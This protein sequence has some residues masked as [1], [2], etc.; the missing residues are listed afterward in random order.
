MT[1]SLKSHDELHTTNRPVNDPVQPVPLPAAISNGNPPGRRHLIHGRFS[2][3]LAYSGT[4]LVLMGGIGIGHGG[5][6]L[7]LIGALIALPFLAET[8]ER[9][10]SHQQDLTDA[11]TLRAEARSGRAIE[12]IEPVALRAEGLELRADEACLIDGCPVEVLS[13]Y[14]DQPIHTNSVFWIFGG[15]L[16]FLG[17]VLGN[18]MLWGRN[19]KRQQDAAPHWRDP[20][21]A[22]LWVTSQRYILHG[23]AG[24]RSWIQ[25][26]FERILLAKPEDDG[27]VIVPHD[28]PNEPMKLKL[29]NPQSHYELLRHIAHPPAA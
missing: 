20:E 1:T 14:A 23:L 7:I 28:A 13:F 17:S 8:R 22:R 26:P 3:S 11:A 10:R 12:A 21:P 4:F 16:A 2:R 19:K 27:I 25:L 24:N 5:V 29:T 18:F 15:P 9:R 6:A